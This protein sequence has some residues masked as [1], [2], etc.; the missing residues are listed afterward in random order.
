MGAM[1]TWARIYITQELIDEM[2]VVFYFHGGGFCMGS[3]AWSTYHS[4]LS[5]K[6][7]EEEFIIISVNYRLAPKHWLPVAYEHSWSA[8]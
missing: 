3:V 8:I 6:S 2:P 1:G 7:A 4:F 5:S